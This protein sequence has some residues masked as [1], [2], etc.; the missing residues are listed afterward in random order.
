MEYFYYPREYGH[1]TSN[2]SSPLIDNGCS[3]L[4]HQRS[5]LSLFKHD[6]NGIRQC[7]FL[8]SG[9]MFLFVF[10]FNHVIKMSDI[11]SFLFL[12]SI[13]LYKYITTCLS[14]LIDIW[15]ISSFGKL[16]MELLWI[17]ICDPFCGNMLSCPLQK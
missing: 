6:L 4:Y 11:H 13:P 15:V 16:W 8:V 5:T 3:D 9:F 7:I 2:H 1:P 17:L 10:R 14:N 12:C